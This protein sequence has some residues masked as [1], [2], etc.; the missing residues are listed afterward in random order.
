MKQLIAAIQFITILPA[1]KNNIFDPKGMVAF[2][3]VVG[4]IIGIML[5]SADRIFLIFW[6]KPVVAVLD[7]CFL[8]LITGA[9]HIDGLGDAADGLLGHRPREKALEIM[10]DSRIGVMGLVAILFGLSIKWGGIMSLDSHRTLLLIIIPSYARG[11]MLFGIKLLNYG[12]PQGGTGHDLFGEPMKNYSFLGLI[13][14]V[15]L[16]LCMGLRGVWLNVAFIYLTGF[17]ILYFK[18]RV[19]CITGD[20]LGTMTE[21][22]EAVLFLAF[23]IG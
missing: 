8:A 21:V 18:N 1:G 23:S 12:R 14:P 13:I 11:S 16:S 22:S 9:F 17:M 10:K 19:G 2:F 6:T 4:I 20:M 5:A 3:P 15:A 7:V